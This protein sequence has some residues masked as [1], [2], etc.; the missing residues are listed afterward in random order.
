MRHSMRATAD[1]S[2]LQRIE[3]FLQS[4]VLRQLSPLTIRAYRQD[5][6]DLARRVTSPLHCCRPVDLQ[7]L[8]G[9]LTREGCSARSIRRRLS[10][11]R[12]FYDWLV[13]QDPGDSEQAR[14]P[15]ANPAR[16]LRL[17]RM[18][19]RLPKALSVDSACAFVQAPPAAEGGPMAWQSIQDHAI[20]EL[21][22]GCGL[23]LSEIVGLDLGPDLRQDGGW[24]D[25]SQSEVHVLG[26]G[27]KRRVVPLGGQASAAV[28]AWLTVR[29][30]L[31]PGSPA[32][33]LGARLARISG[34]SIQRRFERR[35]LVAGL[36][37]QVNPHM[38]RHSFAS[39]LLQSSGDLRAVQELLGHAQI[40]TTQV[41]T[42][43][44][45]QHLA[46]VLD[47]AHP[48]AKLPTTQAE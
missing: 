29:P 38:L 16:G 25:L 24:V 6:T 8:V 41:Y 17:P 7:P 34:R 4:L 23:R 12:S 9:Q 43:L 3:H 39:H 2:D 13:F 33:F 26:K 42:H 18:A 46:K 32:L 19:R 1:P 31:H 40:A 15:Q 11:W 48:R 45:H 37:H 47:S 28:R 20:F 30:G 27:R 21:A 44:D 5:L 36:G 14:S 10:A 35:A 22:Y